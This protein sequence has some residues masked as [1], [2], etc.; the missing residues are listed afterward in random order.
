MK[1]RNLASALLSLF[2]ANVSFAEIT[3]D[4]S[5]EYAF[6][7]DISQNEA[8]GRAE[9]KAKNNA[10]R[11][12]VGEKMTT[13]QIESCNDTGSDFDC[14]L[15]EDTFSFMDSGHVTNIANYS[16]NI[17]AE[18]GASICKVSFTA[19]VATVSQKSDPSY[20]LTAEMQPSILLRD[21][22]LLQV[23][24]SP[25]K[26]S[27]VY[28][29]GWFPEVDKDSFFLLSETMSFHDS[30]VKG[31]FVFPDKDKELMAHL[32]KDTSKDAVSEYLII[33]ASKNKMAH[34]SKISQR[35]FYKIINTAPRDSWVMDRIS[36][37]IVR[38][39][40]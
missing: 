31:S 36:Y 6:G 26:P 34:S 3:V 10:L 7:P 15:F 4:V 33:L 28:V 17:R 22:E 5:A 12:V 32:P 19:T 40:I 13:S 39:T 8:C 20:F 21:G 35:S 14:T 38:K 9:V 29:Y 2:Y 37:K 18:A 16:K 24:I 30:S 25:S 23:Q 1:Y 11:G 27:Y